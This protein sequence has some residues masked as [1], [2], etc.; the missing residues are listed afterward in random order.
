MSACSVLDNVWAG[1][2]LRAPHAAALRITMCNGL[3]CVG[4]H[5][6]RGGGN[7]PGALLFA[8]RFARRTVCLS[9]A[10]RCRRPLPTA[11]VFIDKRL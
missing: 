8:R 4:G 1:M 3:Q 2:R 11:I 9:D 5:E 6:A 10:G 7:E